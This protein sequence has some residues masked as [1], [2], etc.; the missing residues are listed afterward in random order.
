M[1]WKNMLPSLLGGECH[2]NSY[3]IQIQTLAFVFSRLAFRGK[4]S[5]TF[6][7]EAVVG[8]ACEELTLS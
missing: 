6:L 8:F 2:L 1:T 7:I 3:N 4:Y 5:E